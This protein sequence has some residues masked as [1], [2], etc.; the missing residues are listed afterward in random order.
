MIRNA[1]D[2]RRGADHF[3]YKSQIWR[4]VKVRADEIDGPVFVL[5]AQQAL[6]REMQRIDEIGGLEI[7]RGGRADR[8]DKHRDQPRDLLHGEDAMLIWHS[9]AKGMRL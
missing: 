5:Q 1:E 6:T 3:H 9:S 2:Q 4:R 7:L 8:A